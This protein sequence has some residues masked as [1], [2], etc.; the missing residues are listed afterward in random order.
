MVQMKVLHIIMDKGKRVK[1]LL[2]D[3]VIREMRDL[4]EKIDEFRD[5]KGINTEDY[6][7]MWVNLKKFLVRVENE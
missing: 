6:E 3:D 5:Y 1:C 7:Y 2:V 4:E